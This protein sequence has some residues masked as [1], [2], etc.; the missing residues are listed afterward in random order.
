MMPATAQAIETGTALRAP[1]ARPF[2]S[3]AS[4]ARG[5]GEH[6]AGDRAGPGAGR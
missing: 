4:A 1:S 3:T 6:A 5:A 2:Q